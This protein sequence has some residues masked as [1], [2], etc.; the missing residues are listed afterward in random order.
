MAGL[1]L[2]SAAAF[3]T[4][5][6]AGAVAE[7][8]KNVAEISAVLEAHGVVFQPETL[9]SNVLQAVIRAIDPGAASMTPEQ[10][11]QLQ[12]QEKGVYYDIGLKL[13]QTGKIVKVS[14]VTTNSPAQAAG[15]PVGGIL[16]KIDDQIAGDIAVEQIVNRLRGRKDEP[17]TLTIG[18]TDNNSAARTFKLTRTFMQTPVT[19]TMEFWPQKIGYLKINGLFEGSAEQ[20]VT[21]LKDWSTT[22]CV[23]IILDLRGANGLNLDAVG[24]IAG[25]FAHPVPLLFTVK[26]GFNKTLKSYLAAKND[27]PL[28][29]PVLILIDGNTRG[30]A[31]T[32]AAVLQDCQGVILVGMPTRGDD[33]LREPLAIANGNVLYIALRR[34]DLG[35]EGYNGKGL[36]P[37]VCVTPAPEEK[38]KAKDAAVEEDNGLFSRLSEQEKEDRALNT[39]IGNDLILRRAADITLGLKALKLNS[40]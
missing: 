8:Q 34:I 2:W 7:M 28:D 17:V 33:R 31:E 3:A 13:I 14:G 18:S 37:N 26:D 35:K 10:A 29:Q 22:N 24:E 1:M 16:E 4:V 20:I 27:K 21:Q 9:C 23:G 32:L 6:R 40:H 12:E 11:A 5:D 38:G 25:L 30:A 36:K 39:R 19:G 15:V